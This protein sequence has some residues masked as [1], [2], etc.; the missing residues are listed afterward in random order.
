MQSIIIVGCDIALI[1][2]TEITTMQI[3]VFRSSPVYSY[4]RALRSDCV[5]P[6]ILSNET[7]CAIRADLFGGV[8]EASDT[9]KGVSSTNK[10]VAQ[11]ENGVSI[12]LLADSVG[13]SMASTAYIASTYGVK[14]TC[15]SISRDCQ[16]DANDLTWNCSEQSFSGAMTK[17]VM[18]V[19]SD[20][21]YAATYHEEFS[22]MHRHLKRQAGHTSI[23][24]LDWYA[25]MNIN[26]AVS[27]IWQQKSD[28]ATNYTMKNV[29]AVLSCHTEAH[30]ITYES[31]K[32]QVNISSATPMDLTLATAVLD[33]IFTEGNQ[34]YSGF[35]TALIYQA[36]LNASRTAITFD[37]MVEAFSK[38]ASRIALAS[39]AG[40]STPVLNIK[41][42]TSSLVAVVDKRPLYLL[43]IA[44]ELYSV[45]ALV[46]GI[47]AAWHIWK[48]P[49]AK[50]VQAEM[51]AMAMVRR[52]FRQEQQMIWRGSAS[53][54]KRVGVE[55][56]PGGYEFV[57]M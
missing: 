46:Q 20:A 29:F 26:S 22:Y 2:T 39:S 16:L 35:G 45:I 9:A 28:F 3:P 34:Y 47:V 8:D 50:E 7:T 31:H 21:T 32:G 17:P 24:S 38:Q 12:M 44:I 42:G 49:A 14:T 15:D 54:E 6:S 43:D 55:R 53:A 27:P 18:L 30:N 33:P 41:D 13:G 51:T 23:G 40:I 57:M 36:M 52:A 37:D 5:L 48:K 25:V 19:H 1:V 4:G 56:M 11:S 10:V